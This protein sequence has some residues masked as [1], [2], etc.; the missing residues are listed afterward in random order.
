MLNSPPQA[1]R[2]H[3]TQSECSLKLLKTTVLTWLSDIFTHCD[4]LRMLNGDNPISLNSL[5]IVARHLLS[6][7]RVHLG[8]KPRKKVV[9]K[10]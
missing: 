4:P 9:Q 8:L 2:D 1:A 5:S 6:G 7:T 3:S 10:Y